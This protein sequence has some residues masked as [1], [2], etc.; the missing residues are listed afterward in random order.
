MRAQICPIGLILPLLLFFLTLTLPIV[1][2][3]PLISDVKPTTLTAENTEPR[4]TSAG[5]VTTLPKRQLP[6]EALKALMQFHIGEDVSVRKPAQH[7]SE[8]ENNDQALTKKVYVPPSYFYTEKGLYIRC[9]SAR[10]VY[11]RVPYDDPRFPMF[12][13]R[14][15]KD[16]AGDYGT[17][18]AAEIH[19]KAR[20]SAC[21]RCR[22]SDEGAL[23]PSEAGSC[24]GERTPARC[25]LMFA[26]YCTARLGQPAPFGGASIADY[27]AALHAIPTTVKNRNRGYRWSYRTGTLGFDPEDLDPIDESAPPLDI[28]PA[29]RP[30]S[31]W[32]L[33]WDENIEGPGSDFEPTPFDWG[34]D[35]VDFQNYEFSLYDGV[36]DD[37]HYNYNRPYIRYP[38]AD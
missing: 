36:P 31:P 8:A 10:S 21:Q 15:W 22:C 37:Y 18:E 5:A 2:T 20:Q 28:N 24:V 29:S 26:C 17:F 4:T 6:P 35:D 16:W 27:R 1:E 33:R 19:I 14:H 12:S 9:N 38:K 13:L 32:I 34:E 25:V 7:A 30:D 11:D 3:S 23:I